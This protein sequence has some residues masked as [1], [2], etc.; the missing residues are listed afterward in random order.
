[1]K[2]LAGVHVDYD[3]EIRIDGRP[4]RFGGV[5]DA[6]RRASRSFTRSSIWCPNLTAAENIFL[7]REPLIARDLVDR[8]DACVNAADALFEAA[9][10]R[11]RRRNA[12]RGTSDR[13]QQMVEIAKALSL[14]ARILIMDEPTSALSTAECETLFSVVRQLAPRASRSSTSRTAWTK[15]LRSPTG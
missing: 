1:M 8:R 10:H 13:R 11:D 4:I 7:G 12:G 14:D 5:R 9:G 6:E 2:I 15:S 3:G